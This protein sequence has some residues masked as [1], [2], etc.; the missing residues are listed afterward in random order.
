MFP[1]ALQALQL[2]AAASLAPW[3]WQLP[4]PKTKQRGT[5]RRAQKDTLQ[6]T[7]VQFKCEKWHSKVK[8]SERSL[9]ALTSLS[10][11]L[12]IYFTSPALKR[13]AS[14]S[15][16][17]KERTGVDPWDQRTGQSGQSRWCRWGGLSGTSGPLW[18]HYAILT[19]HSYTDQA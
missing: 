12:K 13:S 9:T 8:A 19:L 17:I 16:E 18:A 4:S 6:L 14:Q 2:D 15:P 5:A 1:W 3:S 10:L 11:V 7:S